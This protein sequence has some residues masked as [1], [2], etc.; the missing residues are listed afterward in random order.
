MVGAIRREH[1]A[2]ESG[3]GQ[4]KIYVSHPRRDELRHPVCRRVLLPSLLRSDK[5]SVALGGEPREQAIC[6]AKVVRGSRVAHAGALSNTAQREAFDTLGLEL[7][8][9][10]VKQSSSQVPMMIRMLAAARAPLRT[11]HG[12]V[13]VRFI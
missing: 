11:S 12:H 3:M 4:R 9:G 8:L 2:E 7:G 10:R 6:V 5:P 13:R 1:Q